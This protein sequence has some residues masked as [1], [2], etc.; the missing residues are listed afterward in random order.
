MLGRA[1]A[2]NGL[3][4]KVSKKSLSKLES[5]GSG[6]YRI[7]KRKSGKVMDVSG[8]QHLES[9]HYFRDVFLVFNRT[10]NGLY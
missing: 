7:I 5:S 9:I 2:K 6:Y 10:Y 3:Q 8:Y 4:N 1:Y